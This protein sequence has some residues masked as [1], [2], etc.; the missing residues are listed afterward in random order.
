MTS[1]PA[2]PRESDSRHYSYA[3]YA[4]RGVAEGFDA[5]RFGGPVGR[6]L[7]ETQERVL[8]AALSPVDRQ[9]IVDVGTGTGRAAIGLARAGAT[10]LGLDASPDM[11]DV[12]RARAADAGVTVEFGVADAHALP[13]G[14][15]AVDCAVCLRVLMHAIDWP[16]CVA[17]LCRVARRRVVVDFPAA[18]SFAAARE[19]GAARPQAHRSAGR[20]LPGD[21]R[22]RRDA[23]VR[24]LRVSRRGSPPSIRPADRSC[25]RRLAGCRC[26]CAVERALAA[27]GLLRLFGS[28]VTLVAER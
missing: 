11:L 5:L 18:A 14:D 13:L 4:N 19:P 10:V 22:T 26:R 3:H 25:T 7:L 24:A 17:E 1:G 6:Y 15:R 23:G 21:S 27:L 9:R 2:E 12:A 8:L 28:P 16:A 20:S